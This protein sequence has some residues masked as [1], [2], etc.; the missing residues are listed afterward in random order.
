MPIS[1]L[2]VAPAPGAKTAWRQTS[3]ARLTVLVRL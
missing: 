3:R 2:S 1:E